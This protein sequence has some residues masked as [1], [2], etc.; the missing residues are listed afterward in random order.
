MAATPPP[1]ARLR[2]DQVMAWRA[3]RHHLDERVPA[4]AM[5]EVAG[6]I[7]GLHAQ[8]LS[9]AELTRAAWVDKLLE[10]WG[11]LLKP[12]A[13]L[14]LICFAPGKGQQVRFTRPDTWLG[15][16]TDHDPE[17]AIGRGDPLVPGRLRPGHPRGL[18][19][20]VG[21]PQPGQGGSG[22]CNAWARR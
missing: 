18:R 10:S 12:A 22:C 21:H 1:A 14:G 6:R 2:W 4:K 19:P 11:A 16:W 7:A 9:S 5:L 17:Q 15:G 20:L 8:V 3:A 13:A